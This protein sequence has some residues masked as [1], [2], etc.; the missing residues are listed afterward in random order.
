M[1]LEEVTYE[2]LKEKQYR[3]T[4]LIKCA[5]CG[6]PQ[7]I[8]KLREIFRGF[9]KGCDAIIAADYCL[10]GNAVKINWLEFEFLI[11]SKSLHEKFKKKALIQSI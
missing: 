7:Q 6:Q 2:T 3:G 4:L 8:K 1:Y 5:K 11:K 9:C 10:T